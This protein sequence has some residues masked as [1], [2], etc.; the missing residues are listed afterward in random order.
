MCRKWPPVNPAIAP[1]RGDLNSKEMQTK[2]LVAPDLVSCTG[3]PCQVNPYCTG[4]SETQAMWMLISCEP[5]YT[6]LE[7]LRNHIVDDGVIATLKAAGWVIKG[8]YLA[9][10]ACILAARRFPGTQCSWLLRSL[11]RPCAWRTMG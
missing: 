3:H 7:H 4:L 11:T 8:A 6:R 9:P 1:H 10:G 5:H 2:H